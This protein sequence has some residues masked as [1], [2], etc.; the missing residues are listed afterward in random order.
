MVELHA[1]DRGLH[2][3]LFEEA[4]LPKKTVERVLALEEEASARLEAFL[5]ARRGLTDRLSRGRPV[6]FQLTSAGNA[7]V[8]M[9]FQEQCAG[10]RKV[11]F[12]VRRDERLKIGTPADLFVT[13]VHC[14]YTFQI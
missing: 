13:R 12:E 3:L 7:L 11:S 14:V 2:R 5:R 4:P 6:G 8:G 9:I 10:R 1:K